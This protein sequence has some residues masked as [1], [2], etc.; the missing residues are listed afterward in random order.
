MSPDGIADT[1]QCYQAADGPVTFPPRGVV[2]STSEGDGMRT[3]SI[4]ICV[5]RGWGG[6]Q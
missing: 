4:V 3:V 5:T 1:C 6:S 2:I